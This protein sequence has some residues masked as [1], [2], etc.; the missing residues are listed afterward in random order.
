[1]II[2]KKKNKKKYTKRNINY[3]YSFTKQY[4]NPGK[5]NTQNNTVADEEKSTSSLNRSLYKTNNYSYRL[6]DIK[7][8][9]KNNHSINNKNESKLGNFDSFHSN[10]NS[11]LQMKSYILNNSKNESSIKKIKVK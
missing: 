10:K 3:D 9:N 5:S 11:Y 4:F 1:M 6:I 2:I 7:G 8:Y